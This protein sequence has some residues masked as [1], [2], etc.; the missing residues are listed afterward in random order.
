MAKI[1][2]N[3]EPGAKLS[4]IRHNEF[5]E[6]VLDTFKR[7][8]PLGFK[9]T[10][11]LHEQIREQ[12]MRFKRELLADDAVAETEEEADDFDVGEDFEPLS[13]YEN[14]H[15]P[16][17]KALKAKAKEINDKI[18]AAQREA[19]IREHEAS[20]KKGDPKKSDPVVNPGAAPSP[21]PGEA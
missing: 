8:P 19:A 12:V 15:I 9:K 6:E 14:D 10:L 20:K 3:V 5:G 13:K 4:P 17:I 21:D 7:S 11:S 2:D 16:S 18:K 1:P